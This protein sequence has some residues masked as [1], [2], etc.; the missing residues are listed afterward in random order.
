M[1][2]NDYRRKKSRYLTNHALHCEGG[3]RRLELSFSYFVI[4]FWQNNLPVEVERPVIDIEVLMAINFIAH[5]LVLL[6]FSSPCTVE[7]A[8][9]EKKHVRNKWFTLLKMIMWR[10][11]VLK[12]FQFCWND[13]APLCRPALPPKNPAKTFFSVLF[14]VTLPTTR[15]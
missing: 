9:K 2:T 10:A 4:L 8:N 3:L 6:W 7:L 11:F 12:G 15:L 14:A 1:P 5:W 13:C